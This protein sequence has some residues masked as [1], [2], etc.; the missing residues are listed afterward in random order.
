MQN[1]KKAT[2]TWTER[3]G[4]APGGGLAY[5]V[6][7]K[8]IETQDEGWTFVFS[9]TAVRPGHTLYVEKQHS[10]WME[11]EDFEDTLLA[12]ILK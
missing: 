11:V 3:W 10:G 6:W 9:P 12:A 5:K 8:T 4:F 2:A 1:V 7:F